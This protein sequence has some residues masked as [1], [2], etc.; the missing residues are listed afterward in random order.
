MLD[1]VCGEVKAK[2]KAPVDLLA[3]WKDEFEKEFDEKYKPFFPLPN[4]VIFENAGNENNRVSLNDG[5][6][7]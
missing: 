4:E 6:I 3:A 5:F 2:S 1:V 7:G